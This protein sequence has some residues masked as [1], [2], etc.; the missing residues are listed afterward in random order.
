MGRIKLVSSELK[1]V[2]KWRLDN[3][4]NAQGK[5]QKQKRTASN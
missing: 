4:Q 2:L 5:A 3:L 1:A